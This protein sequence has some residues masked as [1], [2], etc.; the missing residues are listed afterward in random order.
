MKKKISRVMAIICYGM[1]IFLSAYIGGWEMLFEP[2]FILIHDISRGS[3]TFDIAFVCIIK[4]ALSATMAGFIWCLGYLGF[5]H[6]KG[7]EEPD[8]EALESECE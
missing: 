6:F 2:L 8:W 7:K 3:L 4:I 1:G 5:N